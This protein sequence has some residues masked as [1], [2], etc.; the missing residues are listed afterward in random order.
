MIHNMS[1]QDENAALK[2]EN[3]E[4]RR[5]LQ[6]IEKDSNSRI[7]Q[8]P[9]LAIDSDAWVWRI[10]MGGRYTFSSDVVEK[11]LGYAPDEMIGRPFYA[12]F[13]P[14]DRERLR[15]LAM[16]AIASGQPFLSLRNR[17]VRKDGT[18]VI[19]E[20]TAFPIVSEGGEI[21][22]YYGVDR[23]VTALVRAETAKRESEVV[24]RHIFDELGDAVYLAVWEDDGSRRVVEANKEALRRVGGR[25][26]DVIGKDLLSNFPLKGIEPDLK[27][28]QDTLD[29]GDTARYV[30]NRVASDG[31][32]RWEEVVEVPIPHHGGSASLSVN[33]DIT[34]QKRSVD[35]LR[36]GREQWRAQYKGTPL[37]T[38]TWRYIDGDF[39][40][41]DYNDAIEDL[42]GGRI[43]SFIGERASEMY[44]EQP[45]ILRAMREC[46]ETH[47]TLQGEMEHNFVTT[48][49]VHTLWATAGFA[50]PDLVLVHFADISDR[51][52]MERKLREA[53]EDLQRILDVMGEGVVVLDA[54]GRM[55]RLNKKACELFGRAED[56]ILGHD[57][58][59][60]THPDSRDLLASEQRKRRRGKRS[61]YEARML[62]DDGTPFWAHI[63]AVPVIDADGKFQGSVG[64]LRDVTREREAIAKLQQLQEFNE[65]L[66]KTAGV[67][68]NVTDKDGRIVLWNDEAKQI[69]GYSRDEV[70][71]ND[72]I[73]EWLYPDPEYREK[74]WQGQ[75]NIQ[76][77]ED[78]AR[79]IE[80][81]IRHKSGEERVI[82]W[83]G[84]TLYD[85]DGALD[86]W[87]I[88][89]HDVTQTKHNVQR[90]Q[91][92]AAQVERLSRE[93]TRFLSVASHELRTPL[94]I[95]RG[96]IDLLSEEKLR[97]NQRAKIERIQAQLDR[98]TKLLDDLLSVSRIDA[99]KSHLSPAFVDLLEI[100]QKAVELLGPEA[101]AH[102]VK[103]GFGDKH[104]SVIVYADPEGVMQI[105]T[106]ILL[107]SIS[108][109][110]SGGEIKVS[111]TGDSSGGQVSVSDTGIGIS[112][113]EQELVFNEFHRTDRARKMKANGS[114]LG[115]AIVKRLL[116]E[117]NGEICV[118]SAGENKGST[119]LISLPASAPQQGKRGKANADSDL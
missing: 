85:H 99:G 67:W 89:G 118:R 40:L 100:T 88:V 59:F 64:C 97:S 74:V 18:S 84:R 51:K 42:T 20:T 113:Q 50:P 76:K 106:N 34:A 2:W 29:R 70:V 21:V 11:I 63:I 27:T 48:G 32:D 6:E 14:E 75:Q 108:Y 78:A 1:L 17:N 33:R 4:L 9:D 119:F 46:Y 37:P 116:K 28:I 53:N 96:F 69:S 72:K 83:Y 91:D 15:V 30:I 60:W 66:I 114:G 39:E 12:F 45:G 93:K 77:T 49:E 68:I 3:T 87:V 22:G 81:V 43:T 31:R 54:Q 92:Y 73:W 101:M 95:I 26:E 65:D 13:H 107:N 56:K 103:I 7:T 94:T 109:T 23:D 36:L 24:F 115:L 52:M 8:F 80:T 5:R 16:D 61:A 44:P 112:E 38:V 55:T 35:E 82:Q 86:G 104:D 10:D 117:M 57:Y 111:V 79:R 98:F 71:G 90:L 19:L 62:R 102:G 41:I 110:P 58:S 105:L 47:R 25:S